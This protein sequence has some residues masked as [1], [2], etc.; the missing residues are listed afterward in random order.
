MGVAYADPEL[1]TIDCSGEIEAAVTSTP[2]Y[3]TWGG[4][5][6]TCSLG[7]GGAG[8]AI[9]QQFTVPASV[10]IDNRV[11]APS[12]YR[13]LGYVNFTGPDHAY[14]LVFDDENVMGEVALVNTADSVGFG[15]EYRYHVR[16]G[17]IRHVCQ[18]CLEGSLRGRTNI[19]FVAEYV[20]DLPVA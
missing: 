9:Y 4:G 14:S 3:H 16:F 1:D 10:T 17:E 7:H 18:T 15:S 13:S 20:S 2:G 8:F 19:R 6:I 5:S 11:L 12:V